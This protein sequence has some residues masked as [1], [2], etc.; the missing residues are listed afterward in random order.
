MSAYPGTIPSKHTR[1]H[2]LAILAAA[3]AFGVF[4]AWAKGQDGDG[5]STLA[6]LRADLGNVSAPWLLVAFLAGTRSSR[7]WPGALLGLAAT[8]IG[9]FGFYLFTSLV[10]DARGRDP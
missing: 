7:L 6:Q 9:L 4:A 8:M 3:L 1:T 5:V 2:V 10:V